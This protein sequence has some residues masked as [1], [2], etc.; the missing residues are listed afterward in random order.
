MCPVPKVLFSPLGELT[1]LPQIPY[2]DLIGQFEAR[3]ERRKKM[4]HRDGNKYLITRLWLKLHVCVSVTDGDRN[5]LWTLLVPGRWPRSRG[6]HRTN[7]RSM[8]SITSR[9]LCWLRHRSRHLLPHLSSRSVSV[10]L[11]WWID[12]L[13][14]S[15]LNYSYSKA[16]SSCN[17][18]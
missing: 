12:V 1:M 18:L 2:L 7:H 3:K 4:K 14:T 15:Y 9:R 10:A 5:A 11:M 17:N 6:L 8:S 16:Y 13:M